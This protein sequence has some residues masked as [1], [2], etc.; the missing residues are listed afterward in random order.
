MAIN[1]N[2]R[3]QRKLK[4]GTFRA[5]VLASLLAALQRPNTHRA[6]IGSEAYARYHYDKCQKHNALCYRRFFD[7]N[8]L[9]I[10]AAR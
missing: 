1:A 3:H 9:I 6:T 7:F 5:H 10:P 2:K 8:A 4:R